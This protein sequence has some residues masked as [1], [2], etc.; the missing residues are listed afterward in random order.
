MYRSPLPPHTYNMYKGRADD[1]SVMFT[2]S[3]NGSVRIHLSLP[4]PVF[5]RRSALP[6]PEKINFAARRRRKRGDF[7]QVRV[8][9]GGAHWAI[10]PPII[11]RVD[12]SVDVQLPRW[13]STKERDRV[14]HLNIWA[15]GV[16]WRSLRNRMIDPPAQNGFA[17]PDEEHFVGNGQ[18]LA[19]PTMEKFD[20]HSANET[21]PL[22]RCGLPQIFLWAC[23]LGKWWVRGAKRQFICRR[24]RCLLLIWKHS[25]SCKTSQ[26]EFGSEAT[27][28]GA[29]DFY[30]H[31][32]YFATR[33]RLDKKNWNRFSK[34]LPTQF[35]R[36]IATFRKKSTPSQRL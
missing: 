20:S 10:A 21:F 26:I 31:I 32:I 16:Y 23:A 6:Q 17:P 35:T 36:K 11:S 19:I 1:R 9:S 28:P 18:M 4:N 25:L 30:I 29:L 14:S 5:I 2:Q 3:K 15:A 7:P 34:A 24:L 22:T 13:A 33:L 8:Q 12:H 27:K